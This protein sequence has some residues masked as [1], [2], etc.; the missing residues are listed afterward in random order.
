[1]SLTVALLV[2]LTLPHAAVGEAAESRLMY[3]GG[4]RLFT[5]T[6]GGG[7]MKRLPLPPVA[8]GAS[9]SPDG[10]KIAF[11]LYP[12]SN[13]GSMEIFTATADGESITQLTNNDAGETYPSWSA[14]GKSVVYLRGSDIWMMRADGHEKKPLITGGGMA[15]MRSRPAWSPTGPYLAYARQAPRASPCSSPRSATAR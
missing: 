5:S 7:G 1:M 4:Q 6:P 11:A 9:W 12:E 3:T 8:L 15:R 13:T 2:P 10:S 14:G